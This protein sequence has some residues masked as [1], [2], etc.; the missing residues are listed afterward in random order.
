MAYWEE[1]RALAM[2]LE[3]TEHRSK[4]QVLDMQEA[5]ARVNELQEDLETTKHS[6]GEQVCMSSCRHGRLASSFY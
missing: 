1:C 6:Y 5:A 2:R 3:Q 4:Q